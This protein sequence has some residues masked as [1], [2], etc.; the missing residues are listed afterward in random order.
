MIDIKEDKRLAAQ[1]MEEL[2]TGTM[3]SESMADLAQSG[4]ETCE[5]YCGS[6]EY[7]GVDC[8]R[9]IRELFPSYADYKLYL[10]ARMRFKTLYSLGL[11][12]QRVSTETK[13]ENK[14]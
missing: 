3:D 4:I 2:S 13:G 9:C 8:C 12:A 11:L 7:T 10:E 1:W 6:R 5:G 14:K